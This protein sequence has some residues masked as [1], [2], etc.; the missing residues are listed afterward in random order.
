MRAVGINPDRC[1]KLFILAQ[2][3]ATLKPKNPTK[4]IS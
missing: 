4:S 3:L 2:K 1:R